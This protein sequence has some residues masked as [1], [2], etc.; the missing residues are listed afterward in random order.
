[1]K[2]WRWILIHF[3]CLWLIEYSILKSSWVSYWTFP[4][5]KS[6]E[7]YPISNL[8]IELD[9][10][11]FGFSKLDFYKILDKQELSCACFQKKYIP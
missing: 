10:L 1:M 3:K 11:E 5:A 4:F 8:G 9:G 6:F 7:P 2:A